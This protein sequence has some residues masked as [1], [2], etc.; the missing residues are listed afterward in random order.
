MNR[1]EILAKSREEN[2]TCDER[3]KQIKDAS[4]KWTYIAMVLS[5]AI[6]TF[7]RAEQGYPMMDLSA[8]VA[9]S[10]CVGQFYRF[11]KSKSK[12]NL[13]LACITFALFVISTM[14]FIM[15]H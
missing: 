14:R 13:V 11:I 9:I 12:W 7:I 10:V 4:I 6:F 8:T 1:D 3:E 2:K 5:A 15:G